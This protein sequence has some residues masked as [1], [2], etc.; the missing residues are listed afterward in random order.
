MMN[1]IEMVFD[2]SDFNIIGCNKFIYMCLEEAGG[3]YF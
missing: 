3:I 1:P 2:V